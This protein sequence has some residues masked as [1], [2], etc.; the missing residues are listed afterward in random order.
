MT[1]S[2][3]PTLGDTY[4][5]SFGDVPATT[6]FVVNS[7]STS[8]TAWAPPQ[9]AGTVDITVVT[10]AGSSAVS[11]ADHF[12]YSTTSAPTVTG[13]ATT[14]GSTVGGTAVT[15]SG[16]YL[17]GPIA[18]YFGTLAATGITVNSDSSI[19]AIAPPET[20]GTV[21]ITVQT[22]ERHLG[23]LVRG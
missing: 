14:S 20:A 12:T 9:A 22:W 8:V 23:H 6:S 4:G 5:V 18:V 17:T 7:A 15:I 2:P 13:L 11:S 19:T 1:A 16:T 3:A 21:D 10:N